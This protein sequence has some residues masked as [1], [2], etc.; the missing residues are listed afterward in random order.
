MIELPGNLPPARMA[1]MVY[2]LLD[3]RQRFAAPGA[4]TSDDAD[5]VLRT[6][7]SSD[8]AKSVA[9]KYAAVDW[10]VATSRSVLSAHD[11]RWLL[12]LSPVSAGGFMTL[13]RSDR[14]P[15]IWPGLGGRFD[16]RAVTDW[17]SGG[18]DATALVST[19]LARML[20]LPQ[21]AEMLQRM[22][23]VLVGGGPFP[24][25]LRDR[26]RDV[27]VRAVATYG[28]TETLGGCV[29]DGVPWPGIEVEIREGQI[30]LDG[31]N[32]S[33]SY[34][35]GPLIPRPWPTGDLGRWND[36]RLEVVGRVDDLVPVKGVNRHLR[37]FEREALRRPGVLEAVAVA[38]PDDVDGYRVVVFVEDAE[39]RLPR[40]E[41]GKPDRRELLRRARGQR[42]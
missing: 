35:P 41:T 5:I 7:G 40:L 39:Q 27:G 4:P 34:V 12:L 8:A 25:A 14:E 22:E 30:H 38:V 42:R 18:A 1:R 10:A 9:H 23:V 26:C 3:E 16:A 15:L 37:E 36:G 19:Q 11:W 32:L 28:S 33:A 31:P 29:Y 13:A 20:D 24:P 17:Y 6:S 21:G 2:R